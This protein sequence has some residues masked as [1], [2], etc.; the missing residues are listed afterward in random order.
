MANPKVN[1]IRHLVG[2]LP[3]GG[4]LC[5]N[6]TAMV[7]RVEAA[8]TALD[9]L[10]SNPDPMASQMAIDMR[11]TAAKIKLK[12]TVD[13]ARNKT[14]ALVTAERASL[15]ENR[16]KKANLTPSVHAAEIRTVFRGLDSAGKIKFLND[17]V[18]SNDGETIASLVTVPTVISGLTLEQSSSY[19]E[20]FLNKI[21]PTDSRY[22]AEIEDVVGGIFGSA[23]SLAV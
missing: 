12:S 21:A 5:D 18:S 3:K 11:V 19:K 4:P 2:R 15:T 6:V 20:L 23:E 22:V 17:A 7:K 13:E 10:I 1:A 9:D 16:N 14:A 8:S